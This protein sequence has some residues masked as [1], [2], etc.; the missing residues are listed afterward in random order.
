M[1]ENPP[2]AYAIHIGGQ[3]L[4]ERKVKNNNNTAR[5]PIVLIKEELKLEIREI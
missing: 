3:I 1:D 5:E 2:N 4:V